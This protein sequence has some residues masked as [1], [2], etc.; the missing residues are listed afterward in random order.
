MNEFEE[1]KKAAYEEAFRQQRAGRVTTA[2]QGIAGIAQSIGRDVLLQQ[3]IA[4]SIASRL[5]HARQKG[6]EADRLERLAFLMDKNPELLEILG[7]VRDL[8]LL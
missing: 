6:R 3:S 5:H 7:L 4:E 2:S 8:G 1:T